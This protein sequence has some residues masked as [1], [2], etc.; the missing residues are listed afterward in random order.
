L[1]SAKEE[2]RDELEGRRERRERTHLAQDP[3]HVTRE[4][5]VQNGK[6]VGA[7]LEE[8]KRRVA[9]LGD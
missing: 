4:L 3:C 8:V 1:G 5:Q 6:S 7:E 9:H 2:R